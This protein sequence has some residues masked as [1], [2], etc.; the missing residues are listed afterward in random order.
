M[1]YGTV[2]C[3]GD[4]LTYGARNEGFGFPELLPPILDT[5]MTGQ[6]EWAALNCGVCREATWDVLQRAPSVCTRSAAMPGPHVFV[7]LAGTND[8]KS[9]LDVDVFSRHYRQILHWPRRYD[10]P[11]HVCTL[12]PVVPVE[13]PAFPG[14]S[15]EWIKQANV[16]IKSIAFEFGMKVVDLEDLGSGAFC[17]GVHL[18]REGSEIVASRVA[19]SIL[20]TR[21]S[22]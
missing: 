19:A 13:M 21:C 16:A 6:T 5:C 2:T 15:N 9:L 7:L 3:L 10:F 1:I 18:T 17:D 8:A 12:P 11:V 4:S 22:R 20:N 14:A